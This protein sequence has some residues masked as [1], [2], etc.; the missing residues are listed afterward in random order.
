[1]SGRPVSANIEYLQVSPFVRCLICRGREKL[2]R[3]DVYIKGNV[4]REDGLFKQDGHPPVFVHGISLLN[5][6][7]QS[8]SVPEK[9]VVFKEKTYLD[10]F[11]HVV[12]WLHS[13]S[14]QLVLPDLSS[15]LLI[16]LSGKF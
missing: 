11:G 12:G 16:T 7:L 1:M 6:G 10:T 3:L 13:Q 14:G 9:S 8:S 2:L 4:S 15:P 5:R